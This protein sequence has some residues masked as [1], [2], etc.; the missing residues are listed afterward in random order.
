MANN[1]Y[2]I[3]QYVK[4]SLSTAG[5]L[6]D[7]NTSRL[8]DSMYTYTKDSAPGYGFFD[9]ARDAAS[10]YYRSMQEGEM[11]ENQD[12]MLQAR[13]NMQY[14]KDI[15]DSLSAQPQTEDEA[16]E[17][18]DAQEYAIRQLRDTGV[19]TDKRNPT[20]QELQE[21]IENNQKIW[22]EEN[23][24]YLH[25]KEQLDSSYDNYD[26]SQY[27]TRKSNEA[28]QGWGNM[29][30]KMPATMGTSMTSP[31]LQS[32]SMAAGLGGA[33]FGAAAGT[34]IAPGI[35]TAIGAVIGG[36][37]GAQIFGGMQTRE[38]ESH[39]EAF[40]GYYERVMKEAA[41][42]K[43]DT[44]A[45]AKN[46]RMQL[47]ERGIDTKNLGDD[48]IIQMALSDP[49]LK[50][51]STEFNKIADSAYKD[52]RR[53][54]ERNNALGFG[55]AL[56]DL[57]YIVPVVKP[58]QNMLKPVGKML[59]KAGSKVV[60]NALK[61]AMD[62]RFK[63][64]LDIAASG[65]IAR[66]KHITQGISNFLK[67]S[68][69][70]G[71][72]EASEEGAQ[73]ILTDK[74]IRG[75]FADEQSNTSFLDAVADGQVFKDL[76]DDV[77]FR[78]RSLGAVFDI[79][80]EYKNDQQM[81]EEMLSG[82]LMSWTNPQG[83]VINAVRAHSELGKALS[84]PKV[85]KYLQASLE[86]QDQINRSAEFFKNIREGLPSGNTWHEALDILANEL[87]SVGPD[88]KTRKYNL[89][90]LALTDGETAATNEEV[91][92]FIDEQKEFTKELF[93]Y[94]KAMLKKTKNLGLP[95][96]DLDLFLALGHSAKTEYEAGV[97][98]ANK[99]A[100][101]TAISV[102]SGT[103]DEQ[104]IEAVKNM[105]LTSDELTDSDYIRL[106]EIALLNKQLQHIDEVMSAT[107]QQ[108]KINSLLKEYKFVHD[109]DTLSIADSTLKY[110]ERREKLLQSL[111]SATKELIG[112]HKDIDE[113]QLKLI[114][115]IGEDVE[116]YQKNKDIADT[117]VD[118]QVLNTLLKE[119]K[120]KF[121]NPT[122]EFAQDR[123][124]KYKETQHKQH[125]LADEANA[126]AVTGQEA[127]IPETV[128]SDTKVQDMTK[129]AV[130]AELK[131]I[132]DTV[133]QQVEGLQGLLRSIP[134][135]SYLYGLVEFLDKGTQIVGDNAT[136]YARYASRAIK[137]LKYNY[138]KGEQFDKASE[139]EKQQIE[140]IIKAADS[141][142]Q[143]LDR[144]LQL[145][146]EAKA[147]AQRHNAGFKNTQSNSRVY[148]DSDGNR[149][150][151]DM[152]AAEY[153][154]NEGLVV[155]INPVHGDDRTES[156]RK[157]QE[158][159]NKAIER[160]E[161]D[162]VTNP[163]NK[164]SNDKV[165]STLNILKDSVQKAIEN[166]QSDKIVM[167]VSENRDWL[168]QL[169][170]TDNNGNVYQFGQTITQMESNVARK[171]KENRK[172]RNLRAAVLG[173]EGDVFEF[174][175]YPREANKTKAN[176]R[177]EFINFVDGQIK[178]VKAYPL[179]TTYG[180]KQA[181]K[182]MNP[183]YA[184]KYWHGNITMPYRSVQSAKKY[185]ENIKEFERDGVTYSRYKAIEL[186]NKIG[187]QVIYRKEHGQFNLNDFM[188]S[189]EQLGLGQVDETS[190]AGVKVTKDD[191]K[192]MIYALPLI[193]HMYQAHT[194]KQATVVHLADF[195]SK[196]R[197]TKYSNEEF[198]IR[199]G[200]VH[201]LLASFKRTKNEAESLEALEGYDE[202]AIENDETNVFENKVRFRDGDVQVIYNDFDYSIKTE[203]DTGSRLF[204]KTDGT[205]MNQSEVNEYYA[206]HTPAAVNAVSS[207]LDEFVNFLN[208][209][210]TGYTVTKQ[211]LEEVDNDGLSKLGKLLQGILK[212]GDGVISIQ[213]LMEDYV[214]PTVGQA[215]DTKRIKEASVQRARLMLE[216]L[217]NAA[218]EQFLSYQKNIDRSDLAW[219]IQNTIEQALQNNWFNATGAIHVFVEGV[220]I[221]HTN[222]QE[223]IEH[224]TAMFKE[225]E[226]LLQRSK[227]AEQFMSQLKALGY[228]FKQGNGTEKTVT[229]NAEN[230]LIEYFN[231]RKFSRLQ[232]PST[233]A[234]A[235]TTGSATPLNRAVN[236][237][238]FNRVEKHVQHKLS[239]VK[240]LGLTKDENGCYHFSIKKWQ[241]KN[242][243]TSTNA[244]SSEELTQS[245]FNQL[246]EEQKRPYHAILEQITK[247]KQHD[248]MID[249]LQDQASTKPFMQDILNEYYKINEQGKYVPKKKAK[250]SIIRIEITEACEKAIEDIERTFENDYLKKIQ[251]EIKTDDIFAGQNHA[252]LTIAYGSFSSSTG[253][254]IVYYD[255][256]GNK[257]IM[258]NANGTPGALYMVLPAF[259]TSAR[260]QM[261]IKLN[262]KRIERDMAEF[263]AQLM[264]EVQKGTIKL[265][266]FVNDYSFGEF[267]VKADCTVQTL[268]DSLIFTGKDALINNP[269][270][271]NYQKLL[272]IDKDNKV[273]FG[274]NQ[275][276]DNNLENFI[277]FIQSQKT[278]RIDREK[279][280]N[281]NAT[282]GVNI[283]IK[284]SGN[285]LFARREN[286][287][288]VAS[289]VDSGLLTTDLNTS[290][291]SSLFTQPSVY[292]SYTNSRGYKGVANNPSQEGSAANS[293]EKLPDPVSREE[294]A[295]WLTSGKSSEQGEASADDLAT[296]LFK[297]M[298]DRLND[299]LNEGKIAKSDVVV[300]IYNRAKKRIQDGA[301]IVLTPQFDNETNEVAFQL[302]DPSPKGLALFAKG[303]EYG[304]ELSLVATDK[305]GNFLEIDGK[306]LFAYGDPKKVKKESQKKDVS[307][308]NEKEFQQRQSIGGVD[309]SQLPPGST[310][311]INADGSTTI[312]VGSTGQQS[313]QP[314]PSGYVPVRESYVPQSKSSTATPQSKNYEINGDENDPEV[315]DLV[316]KPGMTKDQVKDAVEE[317][318]E[319]YD[320]VP[321]VDFFPQDL[322][323]LYESYVEETGTDV[324]EGGT[325]LSVPGTGIVTPADKFEE[326]TD[327]TKEKSIDLPSI[328]DLLTW[329]SRNGHKQIAD[330]F[331]ANVSSTNQQKQNDARKAVSSLYA[332]WL[333][334]EHKV[335]PVKANAMISRGGTHDRQ[336]GTRIAEY[337]TA[338]AHMGLIF[339]FLSN[340]VEK[341]DF[342]SAIKRV[343]KILG[344]D[345]NLEILPDVK[346]VWDKSRAAKIY[347]YGQCTSASIKLFRDAK[348]N[349][350]VRGSAYHEA[351]HKISLFILSQEQRKNM[352]NQARESNP[353]L[354]GKDDFYVEEFL[355]DRFAEFV[356]DAAQR[357]QGKFY[358]GNLISR[359][360]QKIYDTAVRLINRYIKSNIT[361]EYV[362]MNKLFK[363]MY[364]GR[365]AYLKATK[366][367]IEDFNRVYSGITPYAGMEIDGIEV[368]YDAA[369]YQEIKRDIIGRLAQT[370]GVI[371]ATDGKIRVNMQAVKEQMQK[372]LDKFI[373]SRDLL[374]K[375][376]KADYK[377]IPKKYASQDVDEAL[378]QMHNLI[379][380]YQKVLNPEAWAVWSKTISDFCENTFAIFSNDSTDPNDILSAGDTPVNEN[381]EP[382]TQADSLA[383]S[384]IRDS[385]LKDMYKSTHVS[386]KLLLW[387]IVDG[388]K[389]N[390][391]NMKFTQDG[392][393]V[394]AKVGKLFNDI[395]YAIQGAESVQ[396]MLDKLA[397]ASLKAIED[398][399][400][401]TLQQFY[402]T[403]TL[404]ETPQ[405]I[406]NRVFTDFVRYRHNFVNH[407]YTSDEVY[408]ATIGSNV[409]VYRAS[410]RKG[411]VDTVGESLK[412][413]WKAYIAKSLSDIASAIANNGKKLSVLQKDLR[414][415][416]SK[417]KI[418]DLSSI[419]N[420]L[421]ELNKLYGIRFRDDDYEAAAETIQRIMKNVK[422]T[423]P[424]TDVIDALNG[425]SMNVYNS[426]SGAS[427]NRRNFYNQKMEEL[428]DIKSPIVQ[429]LEKLGT[430]SQPDHKA[431][432]QRGPEGNKVYSIG[433]YNFIT[434][435][436]D[437]R[438]KTAEWQNRMRQ[439]PY[440]S[441]SQWLKEI[442]SS[443]GLG[444]IVNTKLAT[445]LDDNFQDSVAD[446]QVTEVEDLINKLVTIMEGRHV[447]PS[448]ANK[449]FA[450]EIEGFN[451]PVDA[452]N[453][454]LTINEKIIDQFVGYLADEIVAVSDAMKTRDLFMEKLNKITGKNL[455][456]KEFSAWSSEKQEELFRNNKE[457][458]Q[459]L[460]MLVKQYHTK[461]GP[462]S[463]ITKDGRIVRRVFHV[464]LKG[465]GYEF[466]HFKQ[467]GKSI[468]L[469]KELIDQI[470][471]NVLNP[472]DKGENRINGIEIAE[473][474]AN[475]Y[476]KQ[477]REMLRQNIAV[478][479]NKFIETGIISGNKPNV[480]GGSVDV[481]SLFN[482]SIPVDMFNLMFGEKRDKKVNI[483]GNAI[484]QLLANYTIHSMIDLVEFEKIVTGDTGYHR[485]ITS[486]NK[487]YSG[488]VST[489]QIT[490]EIG[491]IINEFEEDSLYDSKTFNT[492]TVNT[493]LVVNDQKFVG[494]MIK[495]LGVNVVTGYDTEKGSVVPIT[496]YTILLDENGK[497]KQEYRN[498]PL[499]ARYLSHLEHGRSAAMINGNPMTEKQLAEVI[500]ANAV[501][502]FVNYLNNDPTDAQV[503]ITAEMFRQLRQREGL[504]NDV[505]E[506]M[507]N[508]LEHFDEITRLAETSKR[509]Q[510]EKMAKTLRIPFKELLDRAKKY[511]Q[512]YTTKD[513]TG[514]DAYK[515]WILKQTEK[516]DA[517]SLKY[518]YYGE[519]AGRE[520]GLYVPIYDKMSLS[521][522]FKIFADGHQMRDMYNF[523]MKNQIQMIKLES[524][525]KSGGIPSFEM[526]DEDGNFNI[527]S[528]QNAPVQ[529]QYFNLIG[530]QLNTDPHEAGQT[531]LL[532]QFMKIAMMNIE[533][534]TI[535]NVGGK[536]ISGED[537]KRLYKDILDHLTAEGLRRF[538]SEWGITP[539]GLDKAKFMKKLQNMAKTQNLP[540]D[541][542]AAFTVDQ[543]G[544]FLIN[545]AALPNIRWI[546]SRI[547][548]EMGKKV[549]DTTTP[550]MPLY[551]VAS[552]G[553][554]NIFNIKNH[555]DKHL[556]MPGERDEH[557]N[558]SKRMQVKLS[559][560]FFDDALKVAKK[561]AAKGELKGYGDLSTFD[562]QRR[563][564][565]NNKE[566][567]ALSYRVP[568]QGQNSTIPVE[569]VDVFPPQRG[570]II[571][572][573]A[574]VT[575][576]TGSDFDID[577]MFLARPNYIVEKGKLKKL[578][579]NLNDALKDVSSVGIL[580]LQNILLDMY[581]A[582]LTSDEHY[583]AANTPLDVCTAP[584]KNFATSLSTEETTLVT[585][586]P[587]KEEDVQK[588]KIYM[589]K[590]RNLD[591]FE[592]YKWD[593]VKGK[594]VKVSERPM[595]DADY[596]KM[597]DGYHLGTVFQT[598]QKIKNAGSDGG[599]GP[600]AL[601]SVFRF[602]TQ[603]SGLKLKPNDYL[604]KLG[605]DNITNLYDRNGEDILD[606]TSALINAHV[607]AVKDNY[608][609][610]V[611]VNGYTYS[612][613]AF[614]TSA[615][616]GNDTFAF[617]TQPILKEVAKNWQ[618]YKKGMVGVPADLSVG[619]KFLE[620]VKDEY[621]ASAIAQGANEVDLNRKASVEEM[622][623]DYLTEQAS[624][625]IPDYAQQVRYL[626]TFIYL[627][628]LAQSYS[629][630]IS[631]AQIDTKKYGIS[632]DEVIS[633][634]QARDQFVSQFNLAFENPE[635]LYDDTFLGEKFAN[636]VVGMFDTFGSTIF[637]FSST[638]KN[639]AD[640]L[641]KMNSKYGRYSKKF[642]KRVGPRI[643]AAYLLPFFN[644]Y[645]SERFGGE[646]PLSKLFIGETSVPSRFADIKRRCLSQGIGLNF[647]NVVKYSPSISGPQFF[648]YDNIIKEDEDIRGAMQLSMS[649]MF[650]SDDPVVR[651][652]MSDFAV[653]NFYITAGTDTN[654]GGLLK[655]SVFDLLPPQHLS[656]VRTSSGTYNE[657]VTHRVMNGSGNVYQTTLDHIM[658]M[659]GLSD[660]TI[661]KTLDY[662]KSYSKN[663]KYS[664]TSVIESV[665][666]IPDVVYIG[667]GS[668]NIAL[669]NQ[670]SFER[671]IKVRDAKG[672]IHMYKLGDIGFAESK[673]G[674]TYA[675]PIYYRVA[676]LGYRNKTRAAL[677]IRADGMIKDG[678]I[679]SL[680]NARPSFYASNYDELNEQDKKKF[681]RTLS[682][683]KSHFKTQPI[684]NYAELARS[685]E[686]L[687][688]Y[689]QYALIDEADVVYLDPQ[690]DIESVRNLIDYAEFKNKEF[691][692]SDEYTSESNRLVAFIND[693]GIKVIRN[694]EQ[695]NVNPE[696][697]PNN[698]PIQT[699]TSKYTR[700]GVRND[701]KTLY[702][703]TDNTDR[704]S[705]GTQ[706]AQGWYRTKY[707]SGGYGSSSN[708]TT[709]VIRG[710]E[711][712]API[713][714]M[715]HF[716]RLYPGMTIEKARWTD[717]DIAEFKE[718]IDDEIEQIKRL[719]NS[720]RFERIVIPQG[721]DGFFNSKIAAIS[722]DSEIG[723]YLQ[724]KLDE[725]EN[726]INTPMT[727]EEKKKIGKKKSEE[728]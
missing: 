74:Y 525:V 146:A 184:A 86:K 81:F 728:C 561:A 259:M 368:A 541:T 314:A 691:Y 532:T 613:T 514:M 27:Y 122:A 351:F 698:K 669:Q 205:Q 125:Q 542:I 727:L 21:L 289:V 321:F 504:W 384:N 559:I 24:N 511:D 346:T 363:D 548:S 466:R 18:T 109:V 600:M 82:F 339:D 608:I 623:V 161:N 334:Q 420:A 425:I 480:I 304:K 362:D 675:N 572:F 647:F 452:V 79:D 413:Q 204:T 54:Y 388:D 262:P 700:S 336:V 387:T 244:T 618:N 459:L 521:P 485:D 395:V 20:T 2:D 358:S 143:Q 684:M 128:V 579:Y 270:D 344:K 322:D 605:I 96:E 584:L 139:E 604:K 315:E 120:D 377:N 439:N 26:I 389:K 427:S 668:N 211:K 493:S 9:W 630:A 437:T 168:S 48:K 419:V 203:R 686:N 683:V 530:K 476:R 544:E 411:N 510:L 11:Q 620:M 78:A 505:D 614:L 67:A 534:S 279:I 235:I 277:E 460:K 463:F 497:I 515:G 408:D 64:G 639:V 16:R 311:H 488:P 320:A 313:A 423:K 381:G 680:F 51:G 649:E 718:V 421:V 441:H 274:E 208:G 701:D 142:E 456:A 131:S 147:K 397:V 99:H 69:L 58:I 393:M 557:G 465:T 38:N 126:V 154:E 637:E 212:Y 651:Q 365:Y 160:I 657:Y 300:R 286:D 661:V 426:I 294:I 642:L 248:K 303:L 640:A 318:S 610:A 578:P 624:M 622:T 246:L 137:R 671:F 97:E 575:A 526:F 364:S 245:E 382:F 63:A 412:T 440:C 562:Q 298:K 12:R 75:E 498:A 332:K 238:N 183:Y 28:V 197:L 316:L 202:D 380:T 265:D 65:A 470:S 77:W 37:G 398:K 201:D 345:F 449:R 602:F 333:Q 406:R 188:T 85:S 656:K 663:K 266:D 276:T 415:A 367:N 33:K 164:E 434:R 323:S 117:M 676:T 501:N 430:E 524:A 306:P 206:N 136:D 712:A 592:T 646:A 598:A 312:T 359:L 328:D 625:P 422:N 432:S 302:T 551:Q 269:I 349:K 528:L 519:P 517:T 396:D 444:K 317:Y 726:F 670:G 523:M 8:H 271:S 264:N 478:T 103:Q 492:L 357:K 458:A 310:V 134:S 114:D 52:S 606:I 129:D 679:H 603:V 250:L 293:K 619:N 230:V 141:I 500:V 438:I 717:A 156:L 104:F 535:Y 543:N 217:Q 469:S 297:D 627:N 687:Y 282:V 254:S 166:K 172:H 704:T 487:R 506:A 489:T 688:G 214:V 331:V 566:L 226:S 260:Q 45:I 190:V 601:N 703:F 5:Q 724:E 573:P 401:Y 641:S 80:K 484:Y 682:K 148:M 570:A 354:I 55:E 436:F 237:E 222:S 92:A 576:Q 149:Y 329:A 372:D 112:R 60:P 461:E 68:A 429:L 17:I 229:T 537:M 435:L 443:G 70:R 565:L 198:N 247:L 340:H 155:T 673:A 697:V 454:L 285:T 124:A 291:D 288:Y 242:V 102:A 402:E 181:S 73:H 471:E 287:N 239:E 180:A 496:D 653:Y 116:M 705:G 309:Y 710:L 59:T 179:G 407:S 140:N 231:N 369:Q 520:D 152:S 709:A 445:I 410:V 527:R 223:N 4:T 251:T 571:S 130:E 508:L 210:N 547:L 275:L 692:V 101:L 348:T 350:I 185:L 385:Y 347:V 609:G 163:E 355:A 221:N 100:A 536:K 40:N 638:Y 678:E 546:Q 442:I 47:Q 182:L 337:Q 135:T 607:D 209:N 159:L 386:M 552:V 586:L 560:K 43:I 220:E 399:N 14:A 177:E 596:E 556:L 721:V 626:N 696:S 486:V 621:V 195:G 23:K 170:S 577:K 616:F 574:G 224:L 343:E 118:L 494:D 162:S 587:T 307:T 583:L 98:N 405:A 418:N 361:P 581:Q 175:A 90:A 29:L 403:L 391:E 258:E 529:Q 655:T 133:T 702:I 447:A 629:D 659:V 301:E 633:F 324:Q 94:R 665:K 674:N 174:D 241:S 716:Y 462:S 632:A 628:N 371:T 392:L 338:A 379:Y 599:I 257:H 200:L 32:T 660:D 171:I 36:L 132:E 723:K 10:A 516:L 93:D 341:E 473:Q 167:N 255:Q 634:I 512:A 374:E 615:G 115:T 539:N 650:N 553:Y 236:Y 273:W 176:W 218:P 549:I 481:N 475:N 631:V 352:Y 563:F 253:S 57:T 299:A 707:G 268:L 569:I 49:S 375:Q 593:I 455:T 390:Q 296:S 1:L 87:K 685:G 41:N 558:V 394:Y 499:I 157:M 7:T 451:Q 232:N 256:K 594:F 417:V 308:S 107:N 502:R 468:K 72:I 585:S 249:F 330:K 25:N 353:E 335:T 215:A 292:I 283:H 595:N 643:K 719:W 400:D 694:G 450:L 290:A 522:I 457:A 689:S 582:V 31:F 446:I 46:V 191:Y 416:K 207:K 681:D 158:K 213:T 50:T 169:S 187:G 35:G 554:D 711:N 474:I 431:N 15:L 635:V 19:W 219:P 110:I 39:M 138:N 13:K 645:V 720:G 373:K 89:D 127:T 690:S 56:S 327:D 404:R 91:D 636:G 654:A 280:T 111:N 693:E 199:A 66:N 464:N 272:Y 376:V 370:S 281:P 30:F 22:D 360:F 597:I 479:I 590:K 383:I 44:K 228:T 61:T 6:T 95:A 667:F 53:L 503:F 666:G 467:L 119:K 34:A 42:N 545:P 165:L 644:Q 192:N 173:S 611:N 267:S 243:V 482:H 153:S 295:E 538:N 105:K 356:Y 428:F 483:N 713:S 555:P 150:T 617:L 513:Q 531:S 472:G 123:V 121:E 580:E 409:S 714:T 305:E 695:V 325:D 3:N 672:N 106:K 233:I 378:L 284:K 196:H 227:N 706:I 326:K 83:L 189:L 662:S 648:L 113:T 507:Y 108:E 589:I 495:V 591:V 612:I 151:V 88:G 677:S 194:G 225:M 658:L 550:G 145:K 652:W 490:S 263:I 533:D 178:R 564:I 715:K 509:V 240:T 234:Q 453:N 342:D 491:T 568:T 725:L 722:R 664:V 414:S 186:F 366:E 518:I 193:A 588:D 278:Y 448:L 699:A 477:I 424:L 261:P 62:K 567:F 540:A 252:P 71:V 144:I 319:K 84:L 708:P 433:A 216:Y 76:L